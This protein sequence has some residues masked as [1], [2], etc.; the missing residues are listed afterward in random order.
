MKILKIKFVKKVILN[1]VKIEASYNYNKRTI[2]IDNSLPLLRKI[3]SLLHEFVH[4]I[5]KEIYGNK[6]NI[7]SIYWDIIYILINP[8][9][10]NKIYSIKWVLKYYKHKG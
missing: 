6:D 5:L 4:Y 2:K 8:S 1:G 7:C 10:K 3:D 9:Y